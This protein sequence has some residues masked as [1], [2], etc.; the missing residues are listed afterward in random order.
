LG[1]LVQQYRQGK[2]NLLWYFV[3]THVDPNVITTMENIA[4]ITVNL[5]KR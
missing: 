2:V 1:I 5:T 3:I 4:P